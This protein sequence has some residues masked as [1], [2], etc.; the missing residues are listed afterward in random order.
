MT[1]PM[2]QDTVWVTYVPAT[3]PKLLSELVAFG[4]V[5]VVNPGTT[6]ILV[7]IRTATSVLGYKEGK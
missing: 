6:Q 5:F 2:P 4:V 1:F 3:L 7:S